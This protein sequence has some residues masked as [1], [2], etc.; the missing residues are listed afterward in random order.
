MA[1][2]KSPRFPKIVYCVVGLIFVH[3]MEGREHNINWNQGI[4]CSAVERQRKKLNSPG[5]AIQ[6][7]ERDSIHA[8]KG[9]ALAPIL[10]A[11]LSCECDC[12]VHSSLM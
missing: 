10:A 4:K 12:L 11:K 9:R 1:Y 6:V 5:K 8:F 3:N 2:F 7:D